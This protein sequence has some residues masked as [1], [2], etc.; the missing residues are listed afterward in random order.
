MAIVNGYCT[1]DEFKNWSQ[2]NG[3]AKTD[4]MELAVNAA[5]RAIDEYCQRHFYQENSGSDL[6]K[7]FLVDGCRV[8]KF[9]PFRDAVSVTSVKSDASGDG[10][11]ETTWAADEYELGP[12]ER[13]PGRPYTR[14]EAVAGR[15]F[16]GYY[17]YGTRA[18]VEVTAVW[19]WAAVPPEVEQACLIKATRLLTRMQSPNGIAGLDQFG[20]VRVTRSEDGD[21]V[22]LLDPLKHPGTGVLV[23]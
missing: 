21:V 5:S 6:A 7:T 9:G 10:T 19:G 20:P 13:A 14:I 12:V 3:T 2:V 1:L 22:A 18:R 15:R 16:P 17:G 11:F 8:L 23:A 4:Q